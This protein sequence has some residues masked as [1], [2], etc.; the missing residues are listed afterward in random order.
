MNSKVSFATDKVLISLFQFC[1]FFAVPGFEFK[2]LH[3]PGRYTTTLATPFCFSYCSDRISC[4]LVSFSLRPPRWPW[5]TSSWSLRIAGFEGVNYHTYLVPNLFNKE[6]KLMWSCK[7]QKWHLFMSM[8]VYPRNLAPM[9]TYRYQ[10][11]SC[12]THFIVPLQSLNKNKHEKG[13]L[14]AHNI[15]AYKNQ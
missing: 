10:Q 7:G 5:T 11:K 9:S 3:L 15:W 8:K 1:L 13:K 4:Y 12:N 2:A 14:S 6:K